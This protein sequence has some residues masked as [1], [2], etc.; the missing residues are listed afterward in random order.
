VIMKLGPWHIATQNILHN[1]LIV[2][3]FIFGS[4]DICF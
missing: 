1:S 2:K 4:I 3:S